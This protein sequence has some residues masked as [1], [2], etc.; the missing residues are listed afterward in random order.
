M[1]LIGVEAIQILSS[2]G[3]PCRF[4]C[5]RECAIE[6]CLLFFCAPRVLQCTHQL[7][8]HAY[9]SDNGASQLR[10]A[11]LAWDADG[12]PVSGGP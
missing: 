3:V 9:R 7:S 8:F 5:R 1:L 11:E 2:I 12:W 10:V 6:Q 4:C